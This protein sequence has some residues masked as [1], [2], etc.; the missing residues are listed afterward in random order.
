M[1]EHAVAHAVREFLGK[2]AFDGFFDSLAFAVH[3]KSVSKDDDFGIR[4]EVM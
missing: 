2:S 4:L 3:W 1:V